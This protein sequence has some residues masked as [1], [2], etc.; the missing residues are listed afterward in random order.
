M[1]S[2]YTAIII[3]P[4]CHNALEF[5]VEN[6]LTCLPENW[7]IVLFH[8]IKNKEYVSTIF[9]KLQTPRLKLVNLYVDNLNQIEYSKLFA[10]KSLL[11]T[12]IPTEHF[13]VFQTDSMFF[14]QNMYLLDSFLSYDYIG[15]PWRVTT[16]EPT[17]QCSFIGNGGF[18]LRK[19]S[20]ML[21]W[22]EAKDWESNQEITHQLEDLFF[23]TPIQNHTMKKPEYSLACTFCVDEVFSQTTMACHKPWVQIHYDVFKLIYPEV[24]TLRLLQSVF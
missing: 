22:I 14:K 23:S 17:Q 18:S 15:A 2:K 3:E 5:V 11:Y 12:H 19:K 8:G 9:T 21:E 7:S 6:A 24:E 16:Y 4:R 10:T 20:K 13:L 1:T